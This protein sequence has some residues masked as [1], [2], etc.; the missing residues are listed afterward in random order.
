MCCNS[1]KRYSF[2]DKNFNLVWD[3]VI[4]NYRP[5]QVVTADVVCPGFVDI[6]NHGIGGSEDVVQG[7]I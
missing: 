7:N 1:K 3:T 2:P 6:H 4:E 5:S